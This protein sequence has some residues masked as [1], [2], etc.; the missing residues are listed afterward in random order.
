[1]RI[2]SGVETHDNLTNAIHVQVHAHV[3]GAPHSKD[4]ENDLFLDV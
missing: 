4:K 3:M 1:M 2:V